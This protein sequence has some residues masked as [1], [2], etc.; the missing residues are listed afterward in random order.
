MLRFPL[1]AALGVVCRV[2]PLQIILLMSGKRPDTG[3]AA[4]SE[5]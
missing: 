1:A 3:T 5:L 4:R 2:D